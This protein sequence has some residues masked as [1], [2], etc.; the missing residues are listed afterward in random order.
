[1]DRLISPAVKMFGDLFEVAHVEEHVA[2]CT[3]RV[4]VLDGKALPFHLL[5]KPPIGHE[6]YGLAERNDDEPNRHARQSVVMAAFVP[7]ALAAT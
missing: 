2:P 5:H 6:R 1:M 7:V 3:R 4:E